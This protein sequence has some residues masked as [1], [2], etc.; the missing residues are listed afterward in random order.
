MSGRAAAKILIP[1]GIGT[2]AGGGLGALVPPEG[3]TKKQRKQNRIGNAV[4]GG[5]LGGSLGLSIGAGILDVDDFGDAGRYRSN[6]NWDNWAED[7]NR[8]YGYGG[9]GGGGRT[10]TP[11]PSAA[12]GE[13]TNIAKKY[14][15]PKKPKTKE[16]LKKAYRRAAV[17]WHPDRAK[18]ED[19]IKY[20]A[21]MS[22]INRWNEFWMNKVSFWKGFHSELSKIASSTL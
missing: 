22:D 12:R 18:P 17:D 6:V 20:N 11:P 5:V 3:K 15:L 7:F 14:G 13:A 8:R 9:G 10:R 1:T 21:A 2:V 4:A 19:R 16:D